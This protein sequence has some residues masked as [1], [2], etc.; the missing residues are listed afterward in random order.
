MIQDFV[1]ERAFG[2]IGLLGQVGGFAFDHDS[3]AGEIPDEVLQGFA[4]DFLFMLQATGQDGYFLLH[5]GFERI[6]SFRELGS[7]RGSFLDEIL[8]KGGEAPVVITDL[9]SEEDVANL[10]EIAV[11]CIV[12]T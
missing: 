8:F 5:E 11:L 9:C 2:L 7:E 1:A 4:A 12:V 6:E 10:F 3:E